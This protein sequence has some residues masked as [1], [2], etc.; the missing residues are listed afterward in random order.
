MMHPHDVI[1]AL[2]DQRAGLNTTTAVVGSSCPRGQSLSPGRVGWH[3]NLGLPACRTVRNNSF[4]ISHPVYAFPRQQPG[5][6]ETNRHG[7]VEIVT[8]TNVGTALGL[9]GTLR[10]GGFGG[11]ARGAYIAVNGPFC[12]ILVRNQKEKESCRESLSWRSPSDY[13]QNVGGKGHPGEIPAGHEG[14]VL[15]SWRKGGPCYKVTK[16]VAELHVWPGFVRSTAGWQA[17]GA[18]KQTQCPAARP[19]LSTSAQCARDN[20]RCN[21]SR[22]SKQ[23]FKCGRFSAHPH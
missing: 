7:Q 2:R 8:A 22:R 3:L 13:E 18:T 14:C 21:C 9:G 17:E 5:W 1:R 23:T 6:T 10:L 20:H 11:A 15:G 12:M 4:F 19:L 16:N